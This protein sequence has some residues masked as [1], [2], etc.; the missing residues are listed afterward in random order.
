MARDE[1][2]TVEAAA[3]RIGVTAES[4]RR[5]LRSGEL[6]GYQLA[7]K[8]GWRTTTAHIEEFIEARKRA[9]QPEHP[10]I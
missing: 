8:L 9:S 5:Y 2:L 1:E 4:V 3:E 6:K 7:R 10:H